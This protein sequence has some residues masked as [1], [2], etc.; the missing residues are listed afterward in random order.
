MLELLGLVANRLTAQ[1]RN[2]GPR[3]GVSDRGVDLSGQTI[4][5]RGRRTRGSLDAEPRY[6]LNARK[7]GLADRWHVGQ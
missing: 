5:D 1:F 2:L 3:T 6:V 4:D 7:A